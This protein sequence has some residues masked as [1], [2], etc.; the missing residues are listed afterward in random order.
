MCPNL[1]TIKQTI[2][3]I[4]QIMSELK[5]WDKLVVEKSILTPHKLV[6]CWETTWDPIITIVYMTKNNVS[7]Y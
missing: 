6:K 1:W 7:L 3:L 2:S 4:V 5:S